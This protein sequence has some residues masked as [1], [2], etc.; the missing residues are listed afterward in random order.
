MVLAKLL[1]P[2]KWV[3]IPLPVIVFAALVFIFVSS[4]MAAFPAEYPDGRNDTAYG[5]S[6]QWVFL[7]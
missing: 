4:R 2:P 6:K 1:N 7:P 3:L 5:D